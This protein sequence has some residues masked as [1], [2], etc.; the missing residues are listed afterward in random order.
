MYIPKRK[1]WSGM[2]AGAGAQTKFTVQLTANYE[3]LDGTTDAAVTVRF[4]VLRR[5][6]DAARPSFGIAKRRMWRQDDWGRGWGQFR[7][8][9][10]DAF[11]YG[12]VNSFRDHELSAGAALTNPT[13]NVSAAGVGGFAEY[14]ATRTLYCW[15]GTVLYSYSG[16]GSTEA[17]ATVTTGASGT[18]VEAREENNILYL[19]Q[20]GA[21]YYTLTGSSWADGGSKGEHFCYHDGTVYKSGDSTASLGHTI[22]YGAAW[23]NS[24]PVGG[25]EDKI[26]AIIS[27]GEDMYVLKTDGLYVVFTKPADATVTS[28]TPSAK[29]VQT[30]AAQ[31]STTLGKYWTIWNGKLW[32]NCGTSL[33]YFDGLDVVLIE[34]PWSV[35][36]TALSQIYSITA[37]DDVLLVGFAGYVLAYEDYGTGK[38]GAWHFAGYLGTDTRQPNGLWFSR[39]PTTNRVWF[40][41]DDIGGDANNTKYAVMANGLFMPSVFAASSIYY[42]SWW[43]DSDQT[44]T[45]WAMELY[46]EVDNC[47][48][49]NTVTMAYC[50]DGG[51]SFVNIGSAITA[52]GITKLPTTGYI[53]D[54]SGNKVTFRSIQLR[55]T[56]VSAGSVSP[57]IKAIEL[58]FQP[59][60]PDRRQ[61][62]LSLLCQDEWEIGTYSAQYTSKQYRDTLWAAAQ[63]DIPVTYTDEYG[64]AYTVSMVLVET[65]PYTEEGSVKGMEARVHLEEV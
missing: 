18:I 20:S 56:I 31:R 4:P 59:R 30:F 1:K 29:P 13:T 14:G 34:Y 15:A 42:S 9:E 63:Q 62:D 12:T 6:A 49:N 11:W 3:P 23:A 53:V 33:A 41:L 43:D 32:F 52:D 2:S 64:D 60:T 16:Y 7:F 24:F 37:M 55:A 65:V 40:G 21:N 51:S 54:G 25:A 58:V 50:V 17:W 5:P 46:V 44:I 22:Y 26:N 8:A 19:S 57:I 10:K 27:M 36:P 61:W 39:I 35:A 38:A 48:A 45:K 47:D 28:F